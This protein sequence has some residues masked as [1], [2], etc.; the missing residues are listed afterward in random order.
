MRSPGHTNLPCTPL[1]SPCTRPDTWRRCLKMLQGAVQAAAA[2]CPLQPWLQRC[3]ALESWRF[4]C[5]CCLGLPAG[6]R[7]PQVHALVCCLSGRHLVQQLRWPCGPQR[8][9]QTWQHACCLLP[10][11]AR[12]VLALPV[13]LPW[14]SCWSTQLPPRQRG[15]AAWQPPCCQPWDATAALP[16]LPAP[17]LGRLLVA[18][19]LQQAP[20]VGV[21]SARGQRQTNLCLGPSNRQDSIWGGM[22]SLCRRTCK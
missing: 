10:A 20:C 5:V 8:G 22:Q 11:A 2:V 18:P 17:P 1:P 16:L 3:L 13:L 21:V 14:L 12:A 7:R 4:W 15:Q 9:R 19:F 6:V